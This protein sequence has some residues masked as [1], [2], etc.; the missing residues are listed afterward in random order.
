MYV[1]SVKKDDKYHPH[2][3]YSDVHSMKLALMDIPI[4]NKFRLNSLDSLDH[5]NLNESNLL[6]NKEIKIDKVE[7]RLTSE[8]ALK[9]IKTHIDT[10]FEKL[11][12]TPKDVCFPNEILDNSSKEF[13]KKLDKHNYE[14]VVD[15]LQDYIKD[16]VKELQHKVTVKYGFMTKNTSEYTVVKFTNSSK[17]RKKSDCFDIVISPETGYTTSLHI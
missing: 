2:S 17:F 15:H 10:R 7:N 11:S 8:I 16:K 3:V 13:W 9:H 6:F 1:V 12:K 5:L 14:T 4:I